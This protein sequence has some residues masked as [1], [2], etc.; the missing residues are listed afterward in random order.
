MPKQTAAIQIF[1]GRRWPVGLVKAA[2]RIGVTPQ[3]LRAV[4]AGERQ[5]A[6]CLREYSDL[7]RE[8]TKKPFKVAA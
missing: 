5:S 6:R 7:C 4:L 8:L 2:E 1:H 3:H